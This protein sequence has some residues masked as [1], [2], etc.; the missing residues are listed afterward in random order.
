M[1]G[2]DDRMFLDLIIMCDYL[3]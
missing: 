2:N 1:T 3:E